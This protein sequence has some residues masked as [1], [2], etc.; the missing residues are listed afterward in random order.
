M[1]TGPELDVLQESVRP[2]KQFLAFS[3]SH[4]E[5]KADRLK[6]VPIACQPYADSKS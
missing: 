3:L 6:S 1:Y 5:L 2:H 4:G